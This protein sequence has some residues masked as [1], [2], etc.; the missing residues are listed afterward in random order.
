[1]VNHVVWIYVLL[2]TDTMTSLLK[3][4]N[5]NNIYLFLDFLQKASDETN[6]GMA[7]VVGLKLDVVEELCAASAKESGKVKLVNKHYM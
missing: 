7:S 1:M 5:N 4:N 6:G 3:N 2:F